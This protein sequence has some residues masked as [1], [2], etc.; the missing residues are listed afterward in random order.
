M[1][2]VSESIEFQVPLNADQR[3][4]VEAAAE[5]ARQNSAAFAA[6]AVV[7]TA[8]RTVDGRRGTWLSDRDRDYFLTLLDDPPKP[9][10]RL[11]RAAQ[12]HGENVVR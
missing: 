3:K 6:G 5:L 4:L 7:G 2:A 1:A 12:Q 9:G 8:R 10:Y 11:M